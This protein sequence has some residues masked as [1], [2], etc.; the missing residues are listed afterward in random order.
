M[1]GRRGDGGK[2]K[3]WRE[4]DRNGAAKRKTARFSP[5]SYMREGGEKNWS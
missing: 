3:R 1:E 5:S 2:E 4:D